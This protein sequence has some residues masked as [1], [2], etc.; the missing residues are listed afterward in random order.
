[1]LLWSAC[2]TKPMRCVYARRA[3]YVT[4]LSVGLS[5]D[6][7]SARYLKTFQSYQLEAWY[8]AFAWV[9]EEACPFWG[10]DLDFQ[11]HR[12]HKGQIQFNTR[13][14]MITQKVLQLSHLNLVYSFPIGL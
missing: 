8:I 6:I 10:R 12:G 3:Y 13:F 7:I 11:D 2:Q 1:M 9:S 4:V 14:C 5:E